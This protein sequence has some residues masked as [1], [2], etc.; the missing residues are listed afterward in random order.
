MGAAIAP[1]SG[2]SFNC[3]PQQLLDHEVGLGNLPW[4]KY[5]FKQYNLLN[6]F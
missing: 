3:S 2:S 6:F 4:Q 1:A 5:Y